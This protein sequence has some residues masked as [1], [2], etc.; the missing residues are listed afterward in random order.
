MVVEEN[1]AR[2][3]DTAIG[4]VKA[5]KTTMIGRVPE[6]DAGDRTWLEL[7]MGGGGDVRIAEAS[8]DAELRVICA[9][10]R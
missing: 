2:R 1:V 5:A 8:K 7:M 3:E 6:E 10:M 4:E 9:G